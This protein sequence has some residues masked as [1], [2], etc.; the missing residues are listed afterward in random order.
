[1]KKGELFMLSKK[2]RKFLL[3]VMVNPLPVFLR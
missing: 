1:V 2:V 3:L